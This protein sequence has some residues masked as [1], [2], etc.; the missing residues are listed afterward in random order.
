MICSKC[1]RSPSRLF[2]PFSLFFSLPSAGL[3]SRPVDTTSTQ[4]VDFAL[5]LGRALQVYGA[6]AHRLEE[7]MRDLLRLTEVEGEF[8]STP[9]AIFA[10]LSHGNERRTELIRVDQSEVDLGK[11]EELVDLGNAVIAGKI[12][13]RDA[14]DEIDRIIAAPPRYGT[15][16][17]VLSFAVTS[18]AACRFFGGGVREMMLASI[19]GLAV[20]LLSLAPPRLPTIGRIFD[21][22]AAFTVSF[23]AVA[24][25][26]LIGGASIPIIT[27][28]GLIILVPGLTLTTAVTELAQRSLAS[29]TARLHGALLVFL[30][31][32][33]GVALGGQA[34]TKLVGTTA[35]RPPVALPAWTEVVAVLV[36]ITTLTI[37][38]RVPKREY[39]WVLLCSSLTYATVKFVS[40]EAGPELGVFAAAIMAGVLS[41]LHGRRF[42]RPTA[43]TRLPALTLLVPGGLGFL[44]ISSL[45]ENDP[46]D[47]LQ[48]AFRVAV[49]AT[50]LATGLII[51]NGIAPP[52]DRK[53]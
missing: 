22:V 6:P 42:E 28:A 18:A 50:A 14:S 39:G 29:G 33:F 4:R 21:V 34:A 43:I 41:N 1:S 23:F 12:S 15:F 36:A 30:M 24:G 5:K 51:A 10:A 47:G 53:I 45:L 13:Q 52:G 48:T 9:T 2:S 32:G 37:L 38:L 19:A 40:I 49:I 20:G 16:P 44:G 11:L 8:F 17:T 46:L 25:S 3:N 35:D 26:A 31:L 27:V 7:A